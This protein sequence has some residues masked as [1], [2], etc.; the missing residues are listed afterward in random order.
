MAR[1]ARIT[2]RRVW[3]SRARPTV[4]AEVV[5]DNGVSGR[6]IA[7]AGASMG[8]GEAIDL[9]D[10]CATLGGLDV[11]RAVENVNGEIS[12]ALAGMDVADQSALDERLIALDGTAQKQ[13]L[14]GNATI[15]VSMAVLQAAAAD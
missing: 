2:G 3:D 6:A 14:G 15:A 8:S 9:R 10:K 13:R 7:P 11:R 4:E 5:L 1:I 12:A